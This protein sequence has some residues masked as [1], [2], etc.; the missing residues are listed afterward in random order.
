M[1]WA[2][3]NSRLNILEAIFV[4]LDTEQNQEQTTAREERCLLR[5]S[6]YLFLKTI[7]KNS[8]NALL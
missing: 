6:E 2:P 7:Q 4:H 5:N 8:N 3:Q 1:N